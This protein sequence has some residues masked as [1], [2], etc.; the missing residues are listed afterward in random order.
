[1]RHRVAEKMHSFA[2]NAV[3]VAE[4]AVVV[5][6]ATLSR[7][8][9]KEHCMDRTFLLNWSSQVASLLRQSSKMSQGAHEIDPSVKFGDAVV[10]VAGDV[11]RRQ[12]SLNLLI[13]EGHRS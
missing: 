4:T 13:R 3:V 6:E 1:M 7:Y 2:C 12:N 8:V 9:E 10:A 11:D 5:A